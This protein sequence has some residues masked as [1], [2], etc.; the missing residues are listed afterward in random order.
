MRGRT[1]HSIR[2]SGVAL[3]IFIISI[4]LQFFSR[5]VFI[6]YLGNEILGLNTTATSLLQF[7]NLAE[8]GVGTAITYALYKPLNRKDYATINEIITLQGWLYRRIAFVV[9][10]GSLVIM[11][12]FPFIFSKMQLPLWYAYAS[13]S[14]LLFSSLLSYFVN[15]KEIL[16]S[17]SQQE[18]KIHYS[19]RLTML[20]KILFQ[21]L[22]IMH[23]ENGYIWWLIL[24][25]SFAIIASI[26][27][28]ITIHKSFPFLADCQITGKELAKK[29]SEITLKIKQYFFHKIA[30]FALFQT[31][32][33][34]IYGFTTLTMVAIY[35]N[36]MLIV[37]GLWGLLN[38][39]FNGMAA[40]IGDLVSEGDSKRNILVM[41]E[42]FTSRFLV[43]G[44][45]SF[46]IF[47]I[48][49]PFVAIWVGKEYVLDR[50]ALL[51][52]ATT[53]FLN[54]IRSV[55]DSYIAAYGL[56]RDIWAPI[57]EAILN[58]GFSVLLGYYWGLHGILLG[59]I[60]SLV[61]IV[62]IW[63]PYF[64]FTEGI[65]APC[66]IYYLMFFKH[67][68]ILCGVSSLTIWLFNSLPIETIDSYSRLIPYSFGLISVFSIL[69]FCGLYATE[70]GMR[71]FVSRFIKRR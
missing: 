28:N 36:Y 11:T 7:L 35:G 62:F 58:V 2:N 55:V 10:A 34:I 5:K 21:I 51:L 44:T 61:A 29:Y 71:N 47:M 18:Y 68:L 48:A 37:N 40:S 50:Y 25:I 8:L 59:V 3:V 16:L 38:A 33:I 19:F 27:L 14:V 54:N 70:L 52:I 60:V 41:R 42:L 43:V 46:A 31:S 64:L 69:M 66:S 57:V 26:V 20:T 39:V 17:A 63:K 30:G 6:D 15:Y 32:S 56:F 65:K 45:L 9:I 1:F 67:L 53:F 23:L 12:F 13:F 49:N 4:V 22:F 24:E